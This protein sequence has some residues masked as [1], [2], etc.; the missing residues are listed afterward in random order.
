MVRAIMSVDALHRDSGARGDAVNTAIIKSIHDICH[1]MG[2]Q[3]IA[4]CVE[5]EST[6]SALKDIGIDYAQGHYLGQP[7][8]LSEFVHKFGVRQ[9]G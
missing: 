9:T 3:T 7:L 6:L 4:E 8:P 5:D 1:T 2:K